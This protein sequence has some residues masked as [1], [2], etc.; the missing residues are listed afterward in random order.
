MSA[1]LFG[2]E[3]S[4]RRAI[5]DYQQNGRGTDEWL[6]PPELIHALGAFDLDPCSPG[7]RRPWNTAAKHYSIED[8][9]LRQD[10]SGR[11]WLNPPYA[12]SAQWLAR[13]AEHGR[14]T[15]LIFARTETRAWF[16]QV[17]PKAAGLLFIRGRVKF[18][19]INGKQGSTA[20]APS[21]L[22]A[23]GD[24]DAAVLSRIPLPGQYVPL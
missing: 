9:G 16:E 12:N 23:Y 10:W 19:Y 1:D 24:H 20:G 4:D 15:A 21:V 14:G 3:H 2:V 13:L 7:D 6:T 8:D 18:H 5:D 17:W 11:V 22:V